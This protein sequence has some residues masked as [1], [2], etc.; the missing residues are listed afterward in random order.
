MNTLISV[1]LLYVFNSLHKDTYAIIAQYILEH[2]DDIDKLSIDKLAYACGTSPNTINKF[3]KEMGLE[4]YKA[5]KSMLQNTVEGR[6]N[7]ISK[8]YNNFDIDQFY[9]RIG[10][11]D[12]RE[13]FDECMHSVVDMIHEADHIY[14][15]GAVYPLSLTL[16]FVEDMILFG[17]QFRIKQIGFKDDR[18][19]YQENDL[20]IL[21]T[22]TG[23]IMTLNRPYFRELNKKN[24]KKIAISQNYL[25][26]DLFNF[27]E[28]IQL[29]DTHH[30]EIENCILIEI[31]NYIKLLYFNKYV[32][33]K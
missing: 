29:I 20:I 32:N 22:I 17:N 31:L 33:N 10:L 19:D 11:N 12:H 8:R 26:N 27:D 5:L 18:Y 2:I 1:L 6:K 24:V 23:R 28:F 4:N 3:C 21:I 7:Q 30:S 14:M 25:I 13:E 15:V 9:R 16:N